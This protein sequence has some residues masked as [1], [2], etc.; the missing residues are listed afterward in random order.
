[1]SVPYADQVAV[2]VGG[3]RF[4]PVEPA[5]LEVVGDR[6]EQVGVLHHLGEPV[7]LDGLDVGE[8]LLAELLEEVGAGVVR[9]RRLVVDDLDAGLLGELREELVGVAE[10]VEG[11]EGELVGVTLALFGGATAA[12]AAGEDDG[13]GVA[14]TV[15]TVMRRSAR[16]F[17]CHSFVLGKL[18]ERSLWPGDQLVGAL[19]PDE[20]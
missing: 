18:E 12:G 20:K 1:M 2:G 6:S 19:S 15:A 17:T 11:G 16:E 3:R 4:L 5:A 9:G 7:D 10:V 8:A 14:A 13:G